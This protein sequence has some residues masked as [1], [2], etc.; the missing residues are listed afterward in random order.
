MYSFAGVSKLRTHVMTE[1][2][3]NDYTL[4]AL[5]CAETRFCA[6]IN[7]KDGAEE[8][9]NNCQLT[10]T[11]KQKFDENASAKEKVW[12]FRKINVDRS[13]AVNI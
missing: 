13:L 7:Y 3:E 10:N 4:C 11:T 9:E 5:R 1:C 12:T 6:A 8:N 2:R